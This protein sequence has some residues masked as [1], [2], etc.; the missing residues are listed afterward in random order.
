MASVTY[1]DAFTV[2]NFLHTFWPESQLFLSLYQ[3]GALELVTEITRESSN[4][5]SDASSF[6]DSIITL[7]MVRR[8]ATTLMPHKR[9]TPCAGG[10]VCFCDFECLTC[11]Q[12]A[13]TQTCVSGMPGNAPTAKLKHIY[14][15]ST[16]FEN[17]H[18]PSILPTKIWFWCP[19]TFVR[20]FWNYYNRKI[21][22]EFK[23]NY[24]RSCDP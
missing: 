12:F 14:L 23:K 17:M 8:R 13:L 9:D 20:E 21:K 24:Y 1:R 2:G 7:H 19:I 18:T 22:G 6:I 10:Q 11:L 4:T 3:Q 15:V 16:S 5:L